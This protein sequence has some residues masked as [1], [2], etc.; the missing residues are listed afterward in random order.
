MY[1]C[2]HIEN[3][4]DKL[5]RIFNKAALKRDKEPKLFEITHTPIYFFDPDNEQD[6]IYEEDLINKI[7]SEYSEGVEIFIIKGNPGTSKSEFCVILKKFLEKKGNKPL[8]LSKDLTYPQ[9]LDRLTTYYEDIFQTPFPHKDKI[10]ALIE[11]LNNE[12]KQGNLLWWLT[13]EVLDSKNAK[14]KQ[15]KEAEVRQKIIKILRGGIKRLLDPQGQG[16]AFAFITEDEF[17]TNY[18]FLRMFFNDFNDFNKYFSEAMYRKHK[19]PNILDII[20]EISAKTRSI[21]KRL[22]IIFEDF[23]LDENESRML[24]NHLVSDST[25]VEYNSTFIIAGTPKYLVHLDAEDTFRERRHLFETNYEDYSEKDQNYVPTFEHSDPVEFVKK[26]L[27]FLKT[28]DGSLIINDSNIYEL[29][30]DDNICSRCG[31]CKSLEEIIFFPFNKKFIENIYNGSKIENRK[32]RAIVSLIG[33][34]LKDYLSGKIP[35]ESKYFKNIDAPSKII[36]YN[37]SNQQFKEFLIWFGNDKILFNKLYPEQQLDSEVVV[38]DDEGESEENGFTIEFSDELKRLRN[39]IHKFKTNPIDPDVEDIRNINL[40]IFNALNHYMEKF[41]SADNRLSTLSKNITVF[42]GRGQNKLIHAGSKKS[43]EKIQLYIDLR[44]FNRDILIFLLTYGYFQKHDRDNLN[45]YLKEKQLLSDSLAVIISFY[46]DKWKQRI[47]FDLIAKDFG[48]PNYYVSLNKIINAIWLYISI[49]SNPEE[50]IEIS[51]LQRNY[52]NGTLNLNKVISDKIRTIEYGQTQLFEIS[53]I[54]RIFEEIAILRELTNVFA[55]YDGTYI[56]LDGSHLSDYGDYPYKIYKEQKWKKYPIDLRIFKTPLRNYWIKIL[57]PFFKELEKFKTIYNKDYRNYENYVKYKKDLEELI[58]IYS[59]IIDESKNEELSK[60]FNKI[61]QFKTKG[62]EIISQINALKKIKEYF[63]KTSEDVNR[64]FRLIIDTK[65]MY[66]S[67]NYNYEIFNQIK[68]TIQL[69]YIFNININKNLLCFIENFYR[70]Y[71]K[72]NI[73]IEEDLDA[74]LKEIEKYFSIETS[75]KDAQIQSDETSSDDGKKKDGFYEIIVANLTD[76]N[77]SLR[78]DKLN[79]TL[80]RILPS[81]KESCLRFDIYYHNFGVSKENAMNEQDQKL[82]DEFIKI[83]NNIP[84]E[85]I[86]NIESSLKK[87]NNELSDKINAKFNNITKEIDDLTI[88]NTILKGV[89]IK[90][91]NS[92]KDSL[93][94]IKRFPIEYEGKIKETLEINELL[95]N[96]ESKYQEINS[97]IEQYLDIEANKLDHED[98]KDF[99]KDLFEKKELEISKIDPGILDKINESKFKDVIY[100]TFS[101]KKLKKST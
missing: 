98:A 64:I 84:K 83:F 58:K 7:F 24:F 21:N 50:I 23:S 28:Y 59:C 75:W 31:R 71:T 25:D 47:N 55:S 12:D 77:N 61:T 87:L 42:V 79:Q 19:S 91:I 34:L 62:N 5:K 68:T 100:I 76:F 8:Y 44:D 3:V 38:E 92:L 81:L 29:S 51:T 67:D 9:F 32:P 27:G 86:K 65:K 45:I 26:Y 88:L 82:K 101:I 18:T 30:L 70:N 63:N 69:I 16:K 96:F 90:E 17:A 56:K 4:Q 74:E 15:E 49:L 37:G 85:S 80:D 57:W 46:I 99:I 53:K 35:F 54:N 72:P 48:K 41:I 1:I 2:P 10:N 52:K 43:N 33:K 89:G 20:K 13:D 97:I 36:K 60:I 95:T 6:D 94:K 14:I 93:E 66:E 39:N 73:Q 11:D 22:Y 40:Y 78:S